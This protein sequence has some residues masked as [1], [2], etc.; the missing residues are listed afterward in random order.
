MDYSSLKRRNIKPKKNILYYIVSFF[1][2]EK[3]YNRVI[4]NRNISNKKSFKSP[5]RIKISSLRKIRNFIIK[6]V[7]V[8]CFFFFI[9][10]IFWVLF[11][12]KAF[13]IK[14]V[15]INIENKKYTDTLN[16]IID[17]QKQ[18][19]FFIWKQDNLFLFDKNKL[20]SS[21]NKLSNDFFYN[22]DIEKKFPNKLI[23]NIKERSPKVVFFTDEY[24]YYFD[25][26]GK[27][28]LKTNNILIENILKKDIDNTNSITENKKDNTINIDKIEEYDI[29]Q[30]LIKNQEEL[31]S[32]N[33]N[34]ANLNLEKETE[35]N[36]IENKKIDL[37]INN[38]FDFSSKEDIFKDYKFP[39]VY[40]GQEIDLKDYDINKDHIV[41]INKIEAKLLN[42]AIN[43]KKIYLETISDIKLI[44]TT[45]IGYEIY[46]NINDDIDQQIEYLGII[47]RDKIKEGI[48]N[49][50]YIDLRFGSKIYYK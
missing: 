41:F 49:I 23:I 28:I 44:I 13:K 50:K 46:F 30:Q 9:L 2:K 8:L 18:E 10:L 31:D 32:N 12:S 1:K 33:L 6:I 14:N 17:K 27:I 40:L 4:I 47:I 35:K 24:K 11:S 45:D 16:F 22:I 42:K 37:E 26:N 34:K 39:E 21:I 29:M 5:N 48:K 43:I 36:N 19:N 7:F 25:E 15:S 3:Q 20:I 38:I